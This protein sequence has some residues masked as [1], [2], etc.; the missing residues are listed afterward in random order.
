MPAPQ[1]TANLLQPPQGVAGA[2][3]LQHASAPGARLLSMRLHRNAADGR[4]LRPAAG[5][6]S[7]PCAEA[8]LWRPLECSW[9][10][11]PYCARPATGDVSAPARTAMIASFRF[12]TPA[13]VWM[14]LDVSPGLFLLH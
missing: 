14:C 8:G 12:L 11:R 13:V 5:K 9:G 4:Y 7:M 6:V 3:A 1:V 2:A 10:A